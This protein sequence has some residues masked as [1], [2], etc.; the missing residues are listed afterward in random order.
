MKQLGRN[1]RTILGAFFIMLLGLIVRVFLPSVFEIFGLI[2]RS[3]SGL[4]GVI[5]MH[6]IHANMPHFVSNMFGFLP[7]SIVLFIAYPRAAKLSYVLIPV[8]SGLL[9]W[10]FGRSVIHVGAS[11]WVYGL[12]TYLITAGIVRKRFWN[13]L[14]SIGL[15]IFYSGLIFGLLPNNQGVS[16]DGH[17]FGAVAGVLSAYMTIKRTQ[18]THASI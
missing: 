13:L 11:A 9:L 2:P 5:G 15:A 16:W 4:K 8:L 7:L 3:I 12:V 18:S 1:I 6:F 14:L 10:C 17:L